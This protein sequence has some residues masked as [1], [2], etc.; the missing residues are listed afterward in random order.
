MN[1]LITGVS[2]GIG[3]ELVVSLVGKGHRVFGL[4]RRE[5]LLEKLQKQVGKEYFDY[6]SVDIGSPLAWSKVISKMDR[7]NFVP[8]VIIFNAAIFEDDLHP[9]FNFALLEQHF[10]INFYSVMKGVE[11]LLK[12]LDSAHFIAISTI[13]R[14]RGSSIEG[15][16][17][18][19]S[20]AAL[21]IAFEAFYQRYKNSSFE[22]TT[23]SLGP[24]KGGMSPFKSSAPFQLSLD[25]VVIGVEEAITEKAP[26]Y[27]Y[28][29]W[30][31]FAPRY[32]A[33][34]V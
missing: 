19:S 22:F 12:K 16:G 9:N 3:W 11:I 8:E 23:V 20:K 14:L 32:P 30:A 17:Y 21:S 6:I 24:V 26:A 5:K 4:A 25:Q 33:A 31:F 34:A 13:A 29:Y 18:S 10:Q 7:Q 28:P 15:V 1:I 2:S 27:Y